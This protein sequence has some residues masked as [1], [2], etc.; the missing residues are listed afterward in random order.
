MVT[1]GKLDLLRFRFT[2]KSPSIHLYGALSQFLISKYKERAKLCLSASGTNP[3]SE[4]NAKREVSMSTSCR[5]F[6]RVDDLAKEKYTENHRSR[7][8]LRMAQLNLSN[9]DE[10]TKELQES[11]HCT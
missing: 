10:L 11:I 4:C 5:E 2:L 9:N 6:F 8:L 1:V 3:C 7:K